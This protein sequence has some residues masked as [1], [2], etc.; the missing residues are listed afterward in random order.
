MT[1]STG[2]SPTRRSP[3]GG[4]RAD[5]EEALENRFAPLVDALAER[6]ESIAGRLEKD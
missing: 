4:P 6:I 5:A 1:S 3:S 2:C